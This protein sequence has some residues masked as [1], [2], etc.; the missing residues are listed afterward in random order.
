VSYSNIIGADP[1]PRFFSVS[2]QGGLGFGPPHLR[3]DV[4]LRTVVRSLAGMQKE[5]LVVSTMGDR[6]WRLLS[7]EGPALGGHEEAPVPLAFFTAGL[8]ASYAEKMLRLAETRG[9]VLHHLRVTLDNFYTSEG[10][11]LG[12]TMTA[13][14]QNPSVHVEARASAGSGRFLALCSDA[15][16]ASPINGLLRG[17]TP[18]FFTLTR[19]GQELPVQQSGGLTRVD[20]PDPTS[21]YAVPVHGQETADE[22]IRR[23]PHVSPDDPAAEAGSS[24]LRADR[25]K[26]TL[27]VRASCT[28]R[29][30]GMKLVHVRNANRRSPV[31]RFLSDEPVET[32]GGGRAPDA[33]TLVSAGI[34]F[35]FMTQLGRYAT[36]AQQVPA[37]YSVVQDTHF[38]GSGR[39]AKAMGQG[40]ADAIETHVHLETAEC[41]ES[42]RTL[43]TMGKQTCYL[44]A[45]C[46]TDLKAMLR[47]TPER[48]SSDPLG[49]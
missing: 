13:R 12:G 25:P 46:G 22:L 33:A 48:P 32:G 39:R 43:L 24:S 14:A 47:A 9:V 31:W 4:A 30:D 1:R 11:A 5:A 16:R 45:L 27:N 44:H 41:E 23:F 20:E 49:F 8:V 28:I 26:R 15:V 37:R 17:V 10:S 21:F 38:S 40:E 18:S 35:C 2:D 36:T 3:R 7:D 6:S 19:N 29:D 42:A 34:A